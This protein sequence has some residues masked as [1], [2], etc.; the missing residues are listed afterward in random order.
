MGYCHGKFRGILLA[1][2]VAIGGG[3]NGESQLPL[4]DGLAIGADRRLSLFPVHTTG[5]VAL[6]LPTEFLTA[7]QE[8]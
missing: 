8:C 6:E 5:L 4:N 7:N 2:P 3:A 1:I